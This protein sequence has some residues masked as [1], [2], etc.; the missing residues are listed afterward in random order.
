[1]RNVFFVFLT[2]FAINL[3]VSCLTGQQAIDVQ[4]GTGKN[5]SNHSKKKKDSL[6]YHP[7]ALGY[8]IDGVISE[9]IGEVEMAALYYEAAHRFDTT[10][11][12]ILA[13]L[14]AVYT[15]LGD[16]D[17]AEKSLKN[18]I[19]KNPENPLYLEI[20][21]DIHLQ[22]GEYS[23]AI[24]IWEKAIAG[25][26]DHYSTR[27]KLIALYE[28]QGRWKDMARHYE[29]ILQQFQDQTAVSAKLGAVYMK[30]KAFDRATEVYAKALLFDPNNAYIMES[31]ALAQMLNKD[32]R[33]AIQTY[34]NLLHLK[35]DQTAIHYRLASLAMQ[36]NDYEKALYHYRKIEKEYAQQ[37]DV[38]RGIGFSLYQLKRVD[39]AVPYFEK[40]VRM[41]DRD[42]LSITL[43]ASILQDRQLYDRSDQYYE[44]ALRI[45]PD[46]DLIL[47]NYSYSLAERGIELE[48]ALKMIKRALDKS[49]DNPHYLDTYGWV[50][51]RQ[52]LYD[53]AFRYIQ[54]S[55]QI[56]STSWEVTMHMGDIY[57]KLQMPLRAIY[58]F[59]RALQL[60]GN[61]PED[62]KPKIE[63]IRKEYLREP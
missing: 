7:R 35:S 49:P 47:N 39:E 63:K 2:V 46:N 24:A 57:V 26:P 22:R 3:L 9:I 31:L 45:D 11:E 61:R 59:E 13:S 41:N 37:F 1:M 20:W 18:L 14:A 34:E 19:R 29:A 36:I 25:A 6:S 56:D 51:Y 28:L 8:F 48:K 27:Y 12:T 52:G 62:L 38:F 33:G 15:D 17:K 21:G 16:L 40:A 4:N 53:Q 10:A 55:Y 30:M 54:K 43:L 58:Y 23:Q 32:Y 42:I 60:P 5:H 44:M 50:L